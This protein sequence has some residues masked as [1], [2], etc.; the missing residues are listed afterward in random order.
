MHHDGGKALKPTENEQYIICLATA[1]TIRLTFTNIKNKQTNANFC[2]LNDFC[3]SK[4]NKTPKTEK[5]EP[6]KTNE[7]PKKKEPKKPTPKIP[8]PKKEPPIIKKPKIPPPKEEPEK[9]PRKREKKIED[10]PEPEDPKIERN[11]YPP[12]DCKEFM[13]FYLKKKY[14]EKIKSHLKSIK[15]FTYFSD[16]IADEKFLVGDCIKECE[17]GVIFQINYPVQSSFLGYLLSIRF[18]PPESEMPHSKPK[19][20]IEDSSPDL[21]CY[22]IKMSVLG[23]Y[24]SSFD[25]FGNVS[26][27]RDQRE[28]DLFTPIMENLLLY[29]N[30][31]IYLYSSRFTTNEVIENI[32]TAILKSENPKITT[33]DL[34]AIGKLEIGQEPP[35]GFPIKSILP[36]QSISSK[37]LMM[38]SIQDDG[39]FIHV[40]FLFGS[41]FYTISV[42]TYIQL[43]SEETRFC[44]QPNFSTLDDDH[45]KCVESDSFFLNVKECNPAN[46]QTCNQKP[47][48][49]SELEKPGIIDSVVEKIELEKQNY[50]EKHFKQGLVE[51]IIFV[52]RTPKEIEDNFKAVTG[53]S[54]EDLMAVADF[55]TM[56]T[57]SK[58]EIESSSSKEKFE[59][60]RRVAP[61][62]I[63]ETNRVV[64][65]QDKELAN[66]IITNALSTPVY[67]F[68]IFVLGIMS[69]IESDYFT[70]KF[71]SNTHKIA[72]TTS[73]DLNAENKDTLVPTFLCAQY[74]VDSDWLQNELK[75][76][77]SDKSSWTKSVFDFDQIEKM[78]K[79]II[80][81]QGQDEAYKG[82][83]GM[84]FLNE[85]NFNLFIFSEFPNIN[86]EAP[87]PRLDLWKYELT[88]Q[89][90]QKTDKTLKGDNEKESTDDN[91]EQQ[92]SKAVELKPEAV[93]HAKRQ[94]ALR[95]KIDKERLK[96]GNT[97]FKSVH[98]S[99]IF[100][101][102]KFDTNFVT[103]TYHIGIINRLLLVRIYE[104]KMG[105]FVMLHVVFRTQY[106]SWEYMFSFTDYITIFDEFEKALKEVVSHYIKVAKAKDMIDPEST[107]GLISVSRSEVVKIIKEQMLDKM[108]LDFVM[109]PEDGASKADVDIYFYVKKSALD[110]SNK[111]DYTS[112]KTSE[113]P[114]VNCNSSDLKLDADAY[115][116]ASLKEKQ[117]GHKKVSRRYELIVFGPDPQTSKE[118]MKT[119]KSQSYTFFNKY[120][121]SYINFV[122]DFVEWSSK[123]LYPITHQISLNSK[124]EVKE[125]ISAEEQ[126]I[127]SKKKN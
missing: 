29:F 11:V 110:R 22:E 44:F 120:D 23:V 88:A 85:M 1:A 57:L 51:W 109:C 101:Q 84:E 32:K 74:M 111:S 127:E 116:I 90:Q 121:I 69:L 102:S 54:I 49:N 12:F 98:D 20:S 60:G 93:E 28:I 113:K 5:P 103:L 124:K 41:Y 61:L 75:K 40:N 14:H 123:S 46:F 122:Q 99:L 108:G 38:Q 55:K 107:T 117:T 3:P 106:F 33:L 94:A 73:T 4:G 82:R 80:D 83:N 104:Y 86:L 58:V 17:G 42:P 62:A 71:D 45:Q 9:E 65:L 77:E 78:E 119:T 56:I 43:K 21:F 19:D 18:Y 115:K 118:S 27:D 31:V 67:S 87:N 100:L 81:G 97:P 2:S 64:W 6:S 37:K 7:P 15:L 30:H 91:R 34:E 47:E 112:I 79:A 35:I 68:S 39:N 52:T 63:E 50:F 53:I 126:V 66:L 125:D 70:V 76:T 8:P 25:C 114:S 72:V 48:E 16:A 105:Y 92:P 95:E 26:D 96:H 10:D 13:K 59:K 24:K 36:G 89:G